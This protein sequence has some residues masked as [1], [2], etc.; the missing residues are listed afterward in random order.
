MFVMN[1]NSLMKKNT[2]KM[3]SDDDEDYVPVV[4]HFDSSPDTE[5]SE[6]TYPPVMFVYSFLNWLFHKSK[7]NTVVSDT[8]QPGDIFNSENLPLSH[9]RLK[10]QSYPWTTRKKKRSVK[11]V[12][13]KKELQAEKAR[14]DFLNKI[15]DLDTPML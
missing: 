6:T 10:Q 15:H 13:K 12:W 4:Y 2:D 1:M 7:N 5:T 3:Y 14:I 9:I 8:L 11:F